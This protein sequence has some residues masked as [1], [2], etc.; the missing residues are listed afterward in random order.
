MPFSTFW[1]PF[2]THFMCTHTCHMLR[3][4]TLMGQ[5]RG[6]GKILLLVTFRAPQ[7]QHVDSLMR[8]ILSLSNFF[9]DTTNLSYA[10]F[11]HV[12]FKLH[13][14]VKTFCRS[15]WV[16]LNRGFEAKWLIG[17][18]LLVVIMNFG[19]VLWVNWWPLIWCL[20]CQEKSNKKIFLCKNSSEMAKIVIYEQKKISSIG[21]IAMSDERL[22]IWT[23]RLDK[24][25]CAMQC[26]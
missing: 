11:S 9:M 12:N 15:I 17:N 19:R 3:I 24:S 25:W 14:L 7:S 6:R 4:C 22:E 18:T 16:F 23:K 20:V 21:S 2:E 1:G 8:F 13:I 5:E 10:N 26:H